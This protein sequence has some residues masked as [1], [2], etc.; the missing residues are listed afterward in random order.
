M[1]SVKHSHKI[2]LILPHTVLLFCEKFF[3]KKNKLKGP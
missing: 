3:E 1:T 2:T